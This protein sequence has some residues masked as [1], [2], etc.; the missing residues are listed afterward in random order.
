MAKTIKN[1]FISHHHKDDSS[2]DG[3]TKLVSKKD[4]VFRNSSIR[5]KPENEARIKAKQ[6]SDRTIARLLRM[7]MR[8]ASQ[9]IVVI[10]K[11]THSRDWVNWEIKTA[12]QLGIPIIGVFEDGLKGQVDIPENLEKYASAV[13]GWRA[14]SVVGALDGESNF[15]KPDGTAWP[16]NEGGHFTC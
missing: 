13:V 8:W 3:L 1:V 2:V 14:D 5:V 9:V 12:H 10:G 4:Y 7:K 16:K 6:L 15:Q 11:E